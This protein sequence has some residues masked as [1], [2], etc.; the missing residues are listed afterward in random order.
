MIIKF[1]IPFKFKIHKFAPPPCTPQAAAL[2]NSLWLWECG[3]YQITCAHV[4][5][6]VQGNPGKHTNP[7]FFWGWADG[8]GVYWPRKRSSW[9]ANALENFAARPRPSL[10]EIWNALSISSFE[11]ESEKKGPPSPRPRQ[12]SRPRFS[13]ISFHQQ[14][15]IYVWLCVC[16]ADES[17]RVGKLLGLGKYSNCACVRV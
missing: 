3:K 5:P 10:C 9:I 11:H 7:G 4:R 13:D 15:C 16:T 2:E 8:R 17:W 1:L 6:R 14:P 12:R